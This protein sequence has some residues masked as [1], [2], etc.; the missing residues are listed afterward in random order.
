MRIGFMMTAVFA[1]ASAASAAE[2][3]WPTAILVNPEVFN[4]RPRLSAATT[5]RQ[6]ARIRSCPRAP[7]LV[8]LAGPTVR[9]V[10]VGNTKAEEEMAKLPLDT[11]VASRRNKNCKDRGTDGGRASPVTETRFAKTRPSGVDRVGALSRSTSIAVLFFRQT[12]HRN[13]GQSQRP[14]IS[15]TPSRIGQVSFA[16]LRSGLERRRAVRRAGSRDHRKE[17]IVVAAGPLACWNGARL[18]SRAASRWV[19]AWSPLFTPTATTAFAV[20]VY[21]GD[22]YGGYTAPIYAGDYYDGDYISRS[23][24]GTTAAAITAASISSASITVA[25]AALPSRLSPWGRLSTGVIDA[26]SGR[27]RQTFPTQRPLPERNPWDVSS[28]LR[29]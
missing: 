25:T 19:T 15:P 24:G 21:A 5:E 13:G 16:A 9:L 29:D 8:T 10:V 1:L 17:T 7:T 28:L 4:R 12:P 6:R 20:P 18:P 11:V 3:D 23:I 26:A 14:V 2:F 27:S 22:H